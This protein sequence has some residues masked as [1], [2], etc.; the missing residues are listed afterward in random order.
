MATTKPSRL[1]ATTFDLDSCKPFMAAVLL[2][3]AM[4]G[5]ALAESI[6][7]ELESAVVGRG[8]S[9]RTI[10]EG[11]CVNKRGPL[12][13][14]CV[15][16]EETSDPAWLRGGGISDTA[17]HLSLVVVR[18]NRAALVASDNGM[19]SY[20]LSKITSASQISRQQAFDAFVGSRARTVWLDGTH[21]STDVKADKK[22]LMGTSLENALDPLGD[23]SYQLS[24]VRSHPGIAAL[25]SSTVGVSPNAARVWTSRP[26]TFAEFERQ[27]TALFDRLDASPPTPAGFGFLSQPVLQAAGV[28]NAYALAVL[29]AALVDHDP[30]PDAAALLEAHVWAYEA[31]YDVIG[32]PN[33]PTFD[34]DVHLPN[35]PLGRV[36]VVVDFQ[37]T[38]RVNLRAT[39]WTPVNA[40]LDEVRAECLS[41]L[42]DPMHAKVYYD[43]GHAITD[44]Q[45]FLGGFTDHVADWTFVDFTGYSVV[46]EKPVPAPTLAAAIGQA[47]DVSLFG[48][49]HRVLHPTGWLASDDGA[50]EVGDF[51]HIDD[52]MNKVSLIHAKAST[53]GAP[54][55]EVSASD[56]EVVVAQGVKNI[57]HLDK[58]KLIAALQESRH[59]QIADATWLNRT[60]RTRD[61]F[62]AV[63]QRLPAN[64]ARELVIL[65]PRLTELEHDLCIAKTATPARIKRFQQ[66]NALVLTGRL[67]AMTVGATF[68]IIA[69]E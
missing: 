15:I 32:A 30:N 9:S 46:D 65:Q 4:S 66:L 21:A 11:P 13:I 1:S 55:R 23:H 24:S 18:G 34:V 49:V 61:D 56:Y 50:G 16:Y 41:Y 38:G 47:A 64:F 19:R 59:R 20:A 54:N 26:G 6:A 35:S 44:G 8:G 69:S 43:S 63:V 3:G 12:Y 7:R 40:M 22:M 67:A 58:A 51:I 14:G 36:S 53:I 33:T 45:C 27:V 2:Q 68:K 60:R 57:R 48:Y 62:L 29:P 42:L 25:G 31:R 39:G 10:L 17:H 37:S 28:A 52:A 5:R